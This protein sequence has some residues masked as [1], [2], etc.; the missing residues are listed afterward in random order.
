MIMASLWLYLAQVTVFSLLWSFRRIDAFGATG[1]PDEEDLSF[2]I[3]NVPMPTSS[4]LDVI[5][6]R[7]TALREKSKESPLAASAVAEALVAAM[8]TVPPI[9][10]VRGLRA[11]KD[12]PHE[13]QQHLPDAV[14]LLAAIR[15][16]GVA[17]PCLERPGAPRGPPGSFRYLLASN[18]K[19]CEAIMPVC[20][21][22]S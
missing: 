16:S 12:V 20:D 8:S 13:V 17:P 7:A 14:D 19:N 6:G 18:L 2:F 11:L 1:P 5:Q 3:P 10:L 15:G 22:L 4:Q 9:S 21:G